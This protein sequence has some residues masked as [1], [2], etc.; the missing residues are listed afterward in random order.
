MSG[1][2]LRPA[3]LIHRVLAIASIAQPDRVD[4]SHVS[5]PR[6]AVAKN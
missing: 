6:Q 3:W 4:T 1:A 2:P 5:A